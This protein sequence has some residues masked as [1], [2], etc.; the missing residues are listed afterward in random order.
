MLYNCIRFF[1]YSTFFKSVPTITSGYNIILSDEFFKHFY[2]LLNLLLRQP[3]T[4]IYKEEFGDTKGVIRIR[5]SKDRQHNDKKKRDK[6]T[7]NDLQNSI[8]K[9]KDRATPSTNPGECKCFVRARS[10]CSTSGTLRV[11]ELLK[12][13][14]NIY[15]V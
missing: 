4:N 14:P 6:R 13:L 8:Q 9:T 10:S 2:T 11:I 12:H 5:K 3:H 7:N 1:S 15:L